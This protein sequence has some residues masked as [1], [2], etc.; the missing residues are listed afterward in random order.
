M[1]TDAELPPG[2]RNAVAPCSPCTAVHCEGSMRRQRNSGRWKN[3]PSEWRLA[4]PHATWR[5]RQS[6]CSNAALTAPSH[7][8]PHLRVHSQGKP[9]THAHPDD[10]SNNC[11]DANQPLWFSMTRPGASGVCFRSPYRHQRARRTFRSAQSE[12]RGQCKQRAEGRTSEHASQ[13][14]QASQRHW[15]RNAKQWESPCDV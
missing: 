11:H 14:A 8:Y 6:S 9:T 4:P 3:K 2:S 1:F 13:A 5:L 12:K 7:R 10:V 15:S